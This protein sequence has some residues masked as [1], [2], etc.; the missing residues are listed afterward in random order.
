MGRSFGG[1][2]GGLNPNMMKQV[3]EL[4]EQLQ[5]AQEELQ[6]A[7]AEGTSGG[8]AVKV[9]VTGGMKIQSIKIDPEVVDPGDVEML[10][11]L[12]LAAITEA[13]DNA[14]GLQQKFLGPLAGGLGIPGLG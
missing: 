14:Q 10:E 7:T 6:S 8:G 5:K 9:V 13:M 2:G 12:I 3:A 11:D 4:Q 1:G